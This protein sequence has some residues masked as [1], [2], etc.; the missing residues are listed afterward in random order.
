MDVGWVAAGRVGRR[1]AP[2][3]GLSAH[4]VRGGNRTGSCG[5]LWE[6]WPLSLEAARQ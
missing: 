2:D 4:R 5:E 6:G 1:L 3:E